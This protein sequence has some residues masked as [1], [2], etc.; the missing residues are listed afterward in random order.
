MTEKRAG[1][2]RRM[3]QE[4]LDRAQDAPEPVPETPVSGAS[5]ASTPPRPKEKDAEG[6]GDGERSGR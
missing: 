5:K 4:I 3:S 2:A 6:E 1:R